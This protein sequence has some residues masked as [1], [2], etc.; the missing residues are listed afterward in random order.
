MITGTKQV[1]E[2]MSFDQAQ[3]SAAEVEVWRLDLKKTEADIE[4]YTDL[5]EESDAWAE[6]TTA[7]ER[8]KELLGMIDAATSH[9]T[10]GL[11]NAGK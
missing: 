7:K 6:R 11:A 3:A 9:L 1:Q 8:R 5:I 2:V 4:H 10:R